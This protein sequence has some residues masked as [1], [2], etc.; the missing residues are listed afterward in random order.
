MGTQPRWVQTPRRKNVSSIAPD[1]VSCRDALTK[2]NQPLRLLHTVRVGLRVA[3]AFPL[4][5]LGLL[6]LVGGTVAD[7]DGLASP[8]DDDLGS[9]Q[10]LMSSANCSIATYVL[11][12]GDGGEVEFDL[13]LGQNVGRGR[14]VHEEVWNQAV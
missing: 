11:A 14:H 4:G 12:L 5:V 6:D 8:L 1:R 2:H 13:G 7:E 10:K 9:D 3:Q